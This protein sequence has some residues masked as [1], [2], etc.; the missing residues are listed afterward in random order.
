MEELPEFAPRYVL[1]SYCHTHDD[2]R[3]SFPL[4]MVYYCPPGV[5][6]AMNMIY[7]GTQ[8]SPGTDGRRGG[9]KSGRRD[10]AMTG[11]GVGRSLWTCAA[12]CVCA[13]CSLWARGCA[14]RACCVAVL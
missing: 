9:G 13:A 4:V 8:V 1:L 10:A 5:K 11:D 7:A 6:P 12:T 3:L 14:L 2:G